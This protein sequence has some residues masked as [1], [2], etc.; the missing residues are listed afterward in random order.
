MVE[1]M[2]TTG[3]SPERGG[4]LRKPERGTIVGIRALLAAHRV[5]GRRFA[6][7]LLHVVA[8]YYALF[9]T[10]ARAASRDYLR[11]VIDEPRFVDVL[12]HIATFAV[13]SF[14]RILLAAGRLEGLT[15]ER[16]GDHHLRAL[17]DARKGAILLGAHLGS[18]EALRASG[19]AEGLV[20]NVLA[21]FANARKIIAML[22]AVAPGFDARVIE[23]DP[24]APHW[25]LKVAE[26]VA[27]GELVAVLG[28][29]T[30]LG[31]GTATADFLGGRAEF[32]TGP[33]ALA[34]VLRCPIYLTFGLYLGDGRYALH[35]EP[36]AESVELPR[37][38]RSARIAVLVQRYAT[39]L[40]AYVRRAPHCWFNFYRFWS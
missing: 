12:R 17:H 29:R 34:S 40:E 36:F 33:Y 14:D 35:C 8:L 25:A 6:V 10:G 39:R 27:N 9:A 22:A 20:V 16:T 26:C 18:F 37:A 24:D 3:L 13:C 32:P 4:W 31:Q 30:G 1:T 15:I 19:D 23:I 28:D 2:A 11:R 21:H 5:F 38:E 7:G